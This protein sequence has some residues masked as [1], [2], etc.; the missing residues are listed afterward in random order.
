MMK[1]I[2]RVK[3]EVAA[4]DYTVAGLFATAVV[5]D[6]LDLAAQLTIITGLS[7]ANL[8]VGLASAAALLVAAD[9]ASLATAALS[10]SAALAGEGLKGMRE[11]SAGSNSE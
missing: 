2:A 5:A 1:D 10:F 9:K 3:S 11:V 7:H 8:G 6:V 4:G